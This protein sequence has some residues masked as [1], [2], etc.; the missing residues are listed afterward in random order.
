MQNYDVVILGGGISGA[1]CAYISSKLQLKTLL[2]EKEN[3]LGGD[4]TGSLVVPVMKSSEEDLNC[5]FYNDLVATASK[6]HVQITYGDNNVGWFNPVILKSVLEKMLKDNLC[7]IIFEA[8]ACNYDCDKKI[9]SSIEISNGILSKSIGSKYYVD[10]T[11][12][13]SFS[14]LLKCEFWNDGESQ[15]DSLRFIMSGI[16]LEEFSKFLKSIDSDENVTTTYRINNNI[17]LS[18]AYTWDENKKWAL[19]PYFKRALEDGILAKEDLAYFQLFTIAA[20]P[21]SIAFNC[22]RLRNYDKNSLIDYSNAIIEGR[23]AINRLSEFCKIYL[24]GFKNAFISSIASKVGKRETARVRCRYD[25]KINDILEQKD[26]QNSVLHSNYPI[27]VHSNKKNES[28]LHKVCS[29]KLPIEAL[30][31]KDYDNLYVIGKILG[32][33]FESQAAL[34]VQAS[35]MSMGEAAAKHIANQCKIL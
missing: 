9:I 32:A 3:Y 20:M 25:Y 24:P 16:N 35:C 18:T 31:S 34:R 11:G 4:I 8:Q 5:E 14:K 2:V 1:A 30:I 26:F 13:A 12:N 21:N 17:H 22:P 27:D 15:P 7:D 10:A 6:L 28:I 29:Y 33:D 19:E 23:E